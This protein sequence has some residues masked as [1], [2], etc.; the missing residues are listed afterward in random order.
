[1]KF[2]KNPVFHLWVCVTDS[3]RCISVPRYLV[4]VDTGGGGVGADWAVRGQAAAARCW[5]SDSGYI[6]D[7]GLQ[8]SMLGHFT[9]RHL[10]NFTVAHSSFDFFFMVI[11]NDLLNSYKTS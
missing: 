10:Q 5:G 6:R 4:L 1:M 9:R 11:S 7:L 2:Q 8:V 3:P